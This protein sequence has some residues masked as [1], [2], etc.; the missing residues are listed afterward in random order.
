MY[1]VQDRELDTTRET[2]KRNI[3]MGL[4]LA[5]PCNAKRRI[6]TAPSQR[7]KRTVVESIY[8]G[9]KP[10]ITPS[11]WGHPPPKTTRK[12]GSKQLIP[13]IVQVYRA[14]IYKVRCT[15]WNQ[16]ASR[17]WMPASRCPY[18]HR[19]WTTRLRLRRS[20]PRRAVHKN[21]FRDWVS[22]FGIRHTH[23]LDF[24]CWFPRCL[25]WNV[26]IY[27]PRCVSWSVQY[28]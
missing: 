20:S 18:L 8:H 7:L 27:L 6:P 2:E 23:S 28:R 12:C 5:F 11:P 21:D 9:L 24:R 16:T 25:L 4:E 13:V 15:W 26:Y 22:C 14:G 19:S 1:V 17:A 3:P 10:I